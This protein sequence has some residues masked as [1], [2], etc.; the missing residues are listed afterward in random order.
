MNYSEQYE[1]YRRA[2]EAAL[3]AFAG[4]LP[5]SST[6]L[7]ESMKYSLLSGGKRI[8]P[9]LFFAFLDHFGIPYAEEHALAIALECI[10]TYSLIHD[11]L[12]A[13]DNDDFR[14]GRPSNHK[15]FGEA[16]AILAG[17][18]LLSEAFDLLLRE[19]LRDKEHLR[20]A[21]VLSDAAGIRG[22]VAGQSEDLKWQGKP[23]EQ[24]ALFSIYE[25]KTARLLAAGP[26][27]AAALAGKCE[28]EA[29]AFGR[30]LGF[31]FQITDDILDVKGD[32]DKLGKSTG[33]DAI[34]DK[35]TCVKLYGM[36]EAE[37]LADDYAKQCLD[38]LDQMGDPA[39]L[40]ELVR[41]VRLRNH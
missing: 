13:M 14:R 38:A 9:V 30:A 5:A 39:F 8:R 25:K 6:C 22:M 37:R 2:F 7:V 32:D 1:L 41:F 36:T 29:S 33:K 26:E 34:E 4:Q 24:A 23:A 12:P 35:L 10:H 40:R 31:L 3:A 11:D 28:K 17:D 16:N 15:V 19:G 27:M 18:G 21:C 20:A